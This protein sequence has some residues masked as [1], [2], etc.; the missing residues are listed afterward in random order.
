ML[1]SYNWLQKYFEDKLPTPEKIAEGII[2]H[3]F[4]VENL[5]KLKNDSIFDIKILPDRAHDCLCHYGV[6]KEVSV[7]FNMDI[8]S[9]LKLEKKKEIKILK[10][11]KSN[12]KI[13]N[14]DDKCFRYMGR[15]IRGIKVK[16]SPQWLKNS[17][18]S[19]GQ[20]SINNIVDATN[21]VMFDV[22]NPIHIFDLDKLESPQIIIRKGKKGEKFIT[23]DR[24]EIEL[25]ESILVIADLK[26]ALSIAGIKGGIKAEVDNNTKNIV[27]EVANFDAVTIRKASKKLGI[28][29]DSVKRF[30]NGLTSVLAETAMEK[31][32]DLITEIALG[33]KEEVIDIYQKKSE[34]RIVSFSSQD[35]N[36]LLGTNIKDIEIEKILNKFEYN[37]SYNSNIWKV[38]VPQL[39]LDITMTCNI[40]E[41]IGRIYGY[42]RIKPELP[43]IEISSEDDLIWLKMN[44][45]RAKL[46][47]A[48]YKEVMNYTFRKEGEIEVLASASDK[49]F[50]RTNLS[51]G[52]KESLKL[53]QINAP[54]LRIDE[55]K[56]FEIGTIFKKTGEEIHVIYAD[57]KNI[58][59]TSLDK[60]VSKE[61]ILPSSQ[62]NKISSD[63]SF[64]PQTFKAWSV[65]PFISRDIAVW[66]PEG[67]D[68]KKLSLIYEELGTDLLV[69][70][71]KLF[72]Q[73]TKAGI[74]PTDKR[75]TSYAFRLVFQ[76]HNR[77]LTDDE[78]NL[79]MAKIEE[80]IHS[81]GWTVR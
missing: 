48:G 61:F 57:K 78:V 15:I 30:E 8:K 62:Q 11:P 79:I 2:F 59:E 27:I 73:F 54:L 50:L 34:D 3:S 71:P 53:N 16:P 18:E 65:Y 60:F 29:T 46:V 49:K 42:D 38:E 10:N 56:I 58:L 81:L 17:L 69:V 47:K 44:Q 36:S 51:D 33:E 63:E 14:Q 19:V 9:D 43:K 32:T 40:V 55:I 66:V 7:I 75:Q 21:Y 1:I 64:E 68:P 72:D 24:K 31:I 12:L 28:F 77:T 41:E 22:G 25:D 74:S 4:E 70:A 35:V 6:A 13:E 26:D 80:K 37:F 20:K 67:T 45:A 39:R 76:S 23:L 5:E 52:I